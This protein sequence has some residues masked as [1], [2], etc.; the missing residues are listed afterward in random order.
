MFFVGNKTFQKRVVS[1]AG[2][3]LL[4]VVTSS[5]RTL[6]ERLAFGTFISHPWAGVVEVSPSGDGYCPPCLHLALSKL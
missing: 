3:M 6:R 2:W 1:V 4:S 5:S